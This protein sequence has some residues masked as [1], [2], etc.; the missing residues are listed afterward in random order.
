MA[1]VVGPLAKRLGDARVAQI[2]LVL[3]T[4]AYAALGFT[5]DLRT[6]VPVLVVWS[7]GAACVEPTPAALVSEAAPAGE[8][9]ATLG[10]NDALSNVALVAAPSLGG[11]VIDKSLGAVGVVPAIA[12]AAA[13]VLGLIHRREDL[14]LRSAGPA[15]GR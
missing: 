14:S 7:I 13:V 2:G 15:P 8:R 9:G 10:F 12:M 4:F 11:L 5:R 6:F 3:G 1:L